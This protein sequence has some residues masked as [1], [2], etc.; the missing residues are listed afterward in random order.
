M[1]GGEI[2]GHR[3][4]FGR[5]IKDGTHIYTEYFKEVIDKKNEDWIIVVTHHNSRFLC[6]RKDHH[7]EKKDVVI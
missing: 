5:T 7:K 1:Y 6:W 2:Y 3:P 4:R